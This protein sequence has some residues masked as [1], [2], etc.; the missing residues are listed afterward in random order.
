ME[1]LNQ[2]AW[3]ESLDGTQQTQL[4]TD[5]SQPTATLQQ[6]Q[7]WQEAMANMLNGFG[8]WVLNANQSQAATTTTMQALAV[9]I[10]VLATQAPMT[11]HSVSAAPSSTAPSSSIRIKEPRQFTGKAS[12]VKAF[13][14]KITDY[15]YLQCRQIMTNYEQSLLF[16]LY[17]ANG[18]P[19]S[20]YQV[21]CNSSPEKLNDF[22]SLVEDFHHHFSDSDLKSTAYHKIKALCQTGSC[23]AYASRF[24]ELVVYLDWTDKSKIAAFKEGLKDQ[25]RDLLVMVRPKPTIFDNFDKICIEFDNAVHENELDKW[26]AKSGGDAS[27]STNCSHPK[28]IQSNLQPVTTTASSSTPVLLPGEPM[29]INATKTKRGPLTQAQRNHRCT[30][31]LCM[32]CGGQH[33]IDSCPNMSDAAKKCFTDKKVTSS[34]LG[35]A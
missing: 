19:K 18:N 12:D 28:Q 14:D 2:N 4:P 11:I 21:I 25:V 26:H 32:Y 22:N 17:L 15:M 33:Q 10:N 20:W 1:S 7:S 9:Q 27:K 35:K 31:K 29:P 8:T 6:P 24:C 13:L 5:T 3:S 30:N 23:A 34:S 16:S